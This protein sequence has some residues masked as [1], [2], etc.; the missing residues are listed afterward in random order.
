M[1]KQKVEI[2]FTQNHK[3]NLSKNVYYNKMLR[4]IEY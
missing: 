3:T 1:R 4:D 2:Y